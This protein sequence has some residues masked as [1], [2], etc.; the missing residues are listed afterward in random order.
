MKIFNRNKNII[1][2]DPSDKPR[3][4]YEKVLFDSLENEGYKYLKSKS[5]FVQTFDFGKRIISLSYNSSFGYISAV[6]YSVKII[7]TDLE[8]LF[9]KVY[10][11]YGWTNWTIH[12][13]LHWTE[14]WLCDKD[15]GEYTDKTI[16]NLAKEFFGEIKPKIDNTFSKICD[17]TSLNEEYNSK[18]NEFIDFLPSSRLEKRIINGLI[19]IM[20]I[21]PANY[22]VTRTQ[23]LQLLDKYKGNDIE[24][25]RAKVDLGLKAIDNQELKIK[26]T[27]N[28]V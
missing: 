11:N 4:R 19:L 6:Q 12:Q 17:Y 13:N 27:A 10:P 24:D 16:N 21:E 14:S 8:K 3:I 9:K 22:Q 2:T 18:P 1:K 25:I 28:N 7:F 15:T 5:E 26:T 23:Y 20:N